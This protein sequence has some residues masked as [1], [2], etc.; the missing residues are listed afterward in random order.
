MHIIYHIS[1]ISL[2]HYVMCPYC[3]PLTVTRQGCDC[4]RAPPTPH[5]PGPPL[6]RT[7]AAEAEVNIDNTHM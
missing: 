4:P 6:G 7:H 5:P 1:Y 2:C 3:L